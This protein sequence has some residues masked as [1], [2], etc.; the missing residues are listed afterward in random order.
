MG[1]NSLAKYA[2]IFGHCRARPNPYCSFSH[3]EMELSLQRGVFSRDL[4]LSKNGCLNASGRVRR[5]EG[6]YINI[7]PIKSNMSPQ[8]SSPLSSFGMYRCKGLQFF[9][10]YLP[11]VEV[12]SQ[13]KR[14]LAKYLI[15]VLLAIL[16]GIGP[17]IR[18]II[19]R[20][21]LLSCVWNRVIPR[22]SSKTIQPTDQTS[23]GWDQ[24]S[25]RITSG[26]R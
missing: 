4:S 12:S 19:A 3:L 11:F 8:S 6:S 17:R 7:F 26:A 10:T 24:P 2:E 9:R 14:P 18:S 1:T 5:L 13:F 22:A 21:S 20:C 16:V 25:S 15:L 23:Q